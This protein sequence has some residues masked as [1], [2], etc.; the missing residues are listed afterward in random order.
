MSYQLGKE[1]Y[2]LHIVLSFRPVQPLLPSPPPYCLS[3]YKM[4]RLEEIMY[5]VP[6]DT[7]SLWLIEKTKPSSDFL[8]DWVP[9]YGPFLGPHYFSFL[10]TCSFLW[11]N[12][13]PSLVRTVS[14][15]SLCLAHSRCPGNIVRWRGQ[16]WLVTGDW[17]HE[18]TEQSGKE[19]ALLAE[20]IF[21]NN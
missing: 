9:I 18:Q 19:R 10:F 6:P 12:P 15:S 4:R 2:N 14:Y 5:K 1:K 21:L 8:Q 3:I 13:Q 17:V 7:D 20:K 16:R 11:L